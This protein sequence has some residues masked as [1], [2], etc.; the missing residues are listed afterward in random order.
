MG[1]TDEQ[2]IT[3][4][5]M[6]DATVNQIRQNQTIMRYQ[7]SSVRMAKIRKKNLVTNIG[8]DEKKEKLSCTTIGI[9]LIQVFLKANWYFIYWNKLS[10]FLITQGFQT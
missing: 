6:L 3:Y 10:V 8:K 1:K 9:K 2:A 4:E 7:F 5:R